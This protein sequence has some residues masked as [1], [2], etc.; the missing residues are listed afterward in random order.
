[1]PGGPPYPH[2]ADYLPEPYPAAVGKGSP[3][4]HGGGDGPAPGGAGGENAVDALRQQVEYYFSEEN[5][6]RDLYLRRLMDGEGFVGLGEIIK[7]NRVI[8]LGASPALLLRAVRASPALEVVE[9]GEGEGD[10]DVALARTKIRS[11]TDPF[12]WVTAEPRDGRTAATAVPVAAA[13]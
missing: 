13:D 7:F 11:A 10:A 9:E 6:R 5:L 8:S 12:K 1:M 4:A 3:R 2:P